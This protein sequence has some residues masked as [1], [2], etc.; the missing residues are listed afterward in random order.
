ML[1]ILN[2]YMLNELTS[3]KSHCLVLQGFYKPT[4][5]I[6]SRSLPGHMARQENVVTDETEGSR[7]GEHTRMTHSRS[8]PRSP[9][10]GWAHHVGHLDERLS[11]G[12]DL[13][14]VY[15]SRERKR[16]PWSNTLET[17]LPGVLT[18]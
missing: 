15:F 7:P 11:L 18:S 16:Q 17:L 2:K 1:N 14:S 10:P 5:L 13:H 3:I 9:G 6:Y 8:P 12:D 4:F